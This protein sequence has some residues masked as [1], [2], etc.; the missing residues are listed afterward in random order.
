[1]RRVVLGVGAVVALAG[2]AGISACGVGTD[3][4]FGLCAGPPAGVD[5]D[6]GPGQDGDAPDAAKPEKCDDKADPTSDAAK[7]CVVDSFALFVDGDAG[8]DANDGSKA[9]PFKRIT[10][11]LAKVGSTGKRRIYICGSGTYA[12][13]LKMTTAANLH[14]GFACSTWAADAAAKPKVAPTDPGYAL[15]IDNVSAAVTVSDLELA[16]ADAASLKD[17]TS[18]IAVFAN[19]ANVTFLRAALR[20]SNGAE[21]AP[22]EAGKQGEVTSQG[23]LDGNTGN[24]A[25]GG[26]LKQCTCSSSA[27]V[28][29][30]GAGGTQ[31]PGNSG[32]P[33]YGGMPPNNG[34]GGA[35][36]GGSCSGDSLG[37]NGADAPA[38]KDATPPTGLGV[39]GPDGWQSSKGADATENGK[40]GQGGG[41]G[42]AFDATSGGGG[43]GCGGCGGFA[44][45]GSSGGG[46]SIALV[47]ND[48]VV[49]LTASVLEAKSA[50]AGGTAGAG[51]AGV[52]GGKPGTGLCLGGKGG[53]GADGGAGAGGA[54]GVA[55]GILYKGTEPTVDGETTIVPGKEGAGGKGGKSPGNDGPIGV[56]GKTLDATKL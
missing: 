36:G 42:G 23:G 38:A 11:A 18:S 45:K 3:C 19:K 2:I 54:G 16:A 47:A 26:G 22:G 20:A 53:R 43:G 14:G 27:T 24:G 51:G 40:P 52:A 32:E 48:S 15:H 9:K 34:A 21:G 37:K 1:M 5:G 33:N 6:G 35:F 13:H 50:G 31:T 17:G 4:D 29:K 8:D 55:G 30:G 12:E 39:L 56:A 41:G 49:T 44:G 25:T 10:T 46:A 28:T 7:E